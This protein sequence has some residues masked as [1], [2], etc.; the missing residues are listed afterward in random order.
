MEGKGKPVDQ[1][2]CFQSQTVRNRNDFSTVKTEHDSLVV[3]DKPNL[4]AI[5]TEW[6]L[7]NQIWNKASVDSQIRLL[8][9]VL[10]IKKWHVR[11]TS[12]VASTNENGQLCAFHEFKQI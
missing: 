9:A 8:A 7:T 2:E 10:Q 3:G 6:G 5:L 11:D 4:E 1:K 12:T